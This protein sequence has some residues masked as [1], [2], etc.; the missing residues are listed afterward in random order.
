MDNISSSMDIKEE[1]EKNQIVVALIPNK[2]YAARLEEIITI[3]P[4]LYKNICYV[5]LNKPYNVLIN[6]LKKSKIDIKKFFFID[7]ITE[8]VEGKPVKDSVLYVSSPRAFTELSIM[9]KKIL[10]KIKIESIIFDSL[11]T[12]LIY[13]ETM[14][15]IRFAQSVMTTLRVRNSNGIFIC[16]K[17]DVNTDLIKD[18]N[19]FADKIITFD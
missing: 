7:C 8:S 2:E 16:L 15:V 14:N 1:I 18:L 17:E 13:E 3:L 11:S 9:I 6:R 19:M 5:S 12:L 4:Q 10:E